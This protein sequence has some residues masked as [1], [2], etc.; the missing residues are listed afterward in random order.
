MR[1]HHII[2]DNNNVAEARSFQPQQTPLQ[3][4]VMEY[5]TLTSIGLI[6]ADQDAKTPEGA[7]D[8]KQV[9]QTLAQS[10]KNLQN[11]VNDK[12]KLEANRDTI[13]RNIH[14]MMTYAIAHLKANLTDEAFATRKKQINSVL[15]K[16][17]NIPK[18]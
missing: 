7:Q 10:N 8:I 9:L 14:D 6:A 1:I 16:Y 12:Q 3:A 13:L 15:S 11:I 18:V 2:N 4:L 17:N 5:L